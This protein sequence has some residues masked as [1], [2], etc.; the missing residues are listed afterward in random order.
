MIG[1][2][3]LWLDHNLL[4]YGP[5][6]NEY[7]Y[8]NSDYTSSLYVGENGLREYKEYV[9]KKYNV[10][11]STLIGIPVEEDGGAGTKGGHIEEGDTSHKTRYFD[12]HKHFGLDYEL[13]TG[14]SENSPVP[15]PLSRITVGMIEDLGYDVDYNK[16]DLFV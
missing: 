10:E 8:W 16:A 11:E 1:I 4:S 2:G 9:T 14:W 15:E 12:G 7:E 13:M 5:Y 3:T 6:Y